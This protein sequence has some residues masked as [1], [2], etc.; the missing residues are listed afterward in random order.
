MRRIKVG[1]CM[2]LQGCQSDDVIEV[3]D[4]STH[5]DIEQEVR[6]WALEH[7]DWWWEELSKDEPEESPNS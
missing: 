3:E 5:S 6:Q 4:E 2:G 1:C 7:F